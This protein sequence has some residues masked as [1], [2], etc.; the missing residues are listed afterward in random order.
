MMRRREGVVAAL[1]ALCLGGVRV[2]LAQQ[3]ELP[4]ASPRNGRSFAKL[5]DFDR[6]TL[7]RIYPYVVPRSWVDY[8]TREAL[9]WSKCTEDVYVVLVVDG[10]GT[11]RN[12]R[13]GDLKGIDVAEDEAYDFAA[14][15]LAEAWKAEK[16]SFGMATLRDETRIGTSTGNWMAPAG[17]LAIASFHAGLRERFGRD[18]FV[19]V[20]VNQQ[21][22]FAF[23]ND[24]KTLSSKSLR[25]AID[26]E[27]RMS[28]KPISRSWMLL[29]GGWP[30]EY[31]GQQL[32]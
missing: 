11:V 3:T 28:P 29:D 14:R 24:A 15:N 23:P 18:K 31:P 12:V 30:R 26:D 16:F 8:S 32:F 13:P 1:G 10:N 17:A 4:K 27:F 6:A 19:A 9:V 7:S 5:P 21:T 22:L 25:L 20:A 2:A